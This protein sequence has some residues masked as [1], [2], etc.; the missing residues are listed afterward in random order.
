[1]KGPS[2]GRLSSRGRRY[3][4]FLLLVSPA[5]L[6]RILTAVYPVLKTLQ[7][8]LYDVN[9]MRQSHHFIGLR[10]FQQLFKDL[11][12][13]DVFVFTMAFILISVVFQLIL[14]MLIATLLNANFRGRQL[15]RTVN[16]IPWAIPTIVAGLAFRWMLDD[17]YG[18]ITDVVC[19]LTANR[20][21][22]LIYP[23]TARLWV[24]LV[25]VWKN[26]PFVAVV[27]LAGLQSVP[28]E[29]YEAAR[30]DGASKFKSFRH[31]TMPFSISLIVTLGLFFFIWQLA[32][33]DLILGM[34]HGGP[35]VATT[36]ISYTIFQQGMLWYNW[37]M[38]SA[39]G[40]VLLLIVAV[41]G[42]LG[43]YLF[44]RYD[45]TI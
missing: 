24:I 16:L 43:L 8:S 3:M 29:L 45:I 6:L 22:F 14:G 1:M 42:M 26:T 11:N 23:F 5:I 30:I 2:R 10:N 41:A 36:V 15:V 34:T 28:P 9:L 17:Q 4:Y 27:L 18:L 35:G 7:L 39:L 33:F 25:N 38:A 37:G 19:R 32:N 31:I 40:V 44:R 13:R 12:N 21:E 20:P